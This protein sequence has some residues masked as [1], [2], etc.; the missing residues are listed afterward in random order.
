MDFIRDYNLKL[1]NT[2]G[3]EA[4]AALCTV[5]RSVDDLKEVIAEN[6]SI[7]KELY[8][9]GGGSNIL[10]CGD[11]D[12]WVLINEL[13]GIE[14]VEE[15]NQEVRLDVSSGENWHQFVLH[16]LE[17]GWYGLENLSLIPGSVGASPIQNIGAYGV[18]VKDFI[19]SVSYLDLLSGEEHH[20]VNDEMNFGYRN[21]IF[22]NDL[23]GKIF[24]TSV[25]F[26]LHKTPEVNIKYKALI[27]ELEN[28]SI[29][30]PG[31]KDV[32]DAVI[33]VRKSKLPDPL[34][35]G[36]SGS[37]FKNPVVA[38]PVLQKIQ[39]E[40]GDV[41]FYPAEEGSV[42]LAAGWL[43]EKAGW[44]GFREGDIGVHEKQ[45]L[46]LVNYGEG[47]GEDIKELSQRIINDILDKFGVL[48]EREVN[49]L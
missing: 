31:P 47:K 44:K 49:I 1:H 4:K 20:L 15:N 45:A 32:S 17:H 48:L 40:Y 11:L 39:E 30:N 23:K 14:V 12:K 7:K 3:V 16:C 6:R 5:I 35:I 25:R 26:K 34:E 22:K 13:F 43:I 33:A 38:K 9:L 2:F 21:S 18:E 37:F 19:E 27:D 8:P 10:L 46:V 36:N 42:K 41:P 24:I 28:R 29:S